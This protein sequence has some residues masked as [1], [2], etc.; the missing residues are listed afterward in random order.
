M[1]LF[2]EVQR[3]TQWYIYVVP[4]AI[5]VLLISSPYLDSKISL[6]D[7]IAPLLIVI[8]VM[9]LLLSFKIKVEITHD[10]II[11]DPSWFPIKRISIVNISRF[12]IGKHKFVGFGVRF[13][14]SLGT[15]YNVKGNTGLLL[16]ITDGKKIFIGSR[17]IQDIV[18]VLNTVKSASQ[19]V[20]ELNENQYIQDQV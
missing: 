16:C 14:T 3:L 8:L 5:I 1:I 13:G 4:I 17:K 9:F 6:D 12:I 11:I 20:L 2:K 18:S 10:E 19:T 15:V 7:V